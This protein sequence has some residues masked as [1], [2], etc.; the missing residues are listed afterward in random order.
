VISCNVRGVLTI[1][2][3]DT[4]LGQMF[5][6]ADMDQLYMLQFVDR[7]DAVV[8]LSRWMRRCRVSLGCVEPIAF[9]KKELALYFRG[10]LRDFAV[11]YSVSGS[12][13]QRQV[14]CALMHIPYG[15]TCSYQQQACHIGRERACRAVANANGANPLDIIIPCHRVIHQNGGL[16]GYGGGVERKA[17][18]IHHEQYYACNI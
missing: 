5:A 4:P 3:L 2:W 17:W 10:M 13:F 18:L 15:H 16:G 8:K 1:S 12:L 7:P 9:V 11:P 6:V 14:W